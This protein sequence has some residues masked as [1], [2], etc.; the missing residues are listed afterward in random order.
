[1]RG[2]QSGE[3]ES[4]DQGS[5]ESIPIRET[6]A[7]QLLKQSASQVRHWSSKADKEELEEGEDE[8]DEEG[9][10]LEPPGSLAKEKN[11]MDWGKNTTTQN[12]SFRKEK[13]KAEALSAIQSK[14]FWG[15]SDD[16]NSDIEIALRPQSWKSGDDTDDFYD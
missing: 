9:S 3:E 13:T 6:K 14:A 8:D 2:V 12:S 7:Y 1:M 15:E 11:R 16:S 10:S 5:L 4:A